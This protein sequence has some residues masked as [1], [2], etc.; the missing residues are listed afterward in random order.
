MQKEGWKGLFLPENKRLR[1]HVAL[2]LLVGVLLLVAG[3][4]SFSSGKEQAEV[5]QKQEKEG[6][7][8]SAGRET[9]QRMAEVLS[10]IAGAGRVEVMLT[11]RRTEEKTVAREE[12]REESAAAEGDKTTE[13]LR[14]ERKAV[15][16]ED[17]NGNTTPLLLSE[18]APQAEGVVIVAEGGGDPSVCQALNQAAQAVLDVPAHKIVVLKMK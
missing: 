8:L 1:S 15:L 7:A 5:P 6:M 13:M 18:T 11:Y 14:L 2:A 10:Q 12:L 9:E 17:R 4:G 3:K 16:L